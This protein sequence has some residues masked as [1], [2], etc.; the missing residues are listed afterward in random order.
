MISRVKI[1]NKIKS[2][3]TTYFYVSEHS[4]SFLLQFFC[5]GLGG[6]PPPLVANIL[7]FIDAFPKLFLH[8]W[9]FNP[10]WQCDVKVEVQVRIREHQ[11]HLRVPQIWVHSGKK[12]WNRGGRGAKS[13]YQILSFCTLGREGAGLKTSKRSNNIFPHFY[14]KKKYIYDTWIINKLMNNLNKSMWHVNK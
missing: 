3:Q 8:L 13:T 9:I 6:W 14:M 7:F 11:G 2:F 1:Q 10:T 4:A 12:I 5:C